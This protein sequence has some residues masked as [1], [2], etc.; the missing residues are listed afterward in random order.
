INLNSPSRVL[1]SDFV[2]E[3]PIGPGVGT[4]TPAV[5]ALTTAEEE[6]LRAELVKVE[7]EIV[8]LRQVLAAKE[9]HCGELKRRLGLSALEGLKQNLSRSWHDVQV[10]NAY[11]KT[12]ETLSQAGQKTSAAL[13]T[14]GSAIS[15]KLGDMRAHPFS[16]SFSSHSIRHSISMPAMRNSAA[17]KSFE[18]RVGT[19]KSKVAGGGENGGDHLAASAAGGT[20]PLPEHAPF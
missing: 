13:S 11:K 16:H 8:T 17:F 1:L 6:E 3:A 9:R 2:S 5:Q 12:Q 18:D 7:E 14:M 4:Q 19:I 15:R 20:Q 10:S